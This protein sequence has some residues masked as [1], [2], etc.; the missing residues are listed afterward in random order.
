[1]PIAE[2]I[3]L[4]HFVK[5]AKSTA[6][7]H[8]EERKDVVLEEGEKGRKDVFSLLV[9]ANK[10]E[11]AKYKMSEDKI[12]CQFSYVL[13]FAIHFVSQ[14]SVIL[15]G[16]RTMVLAGHDTTANTMSWTLYERS[17]RPE[18]QHRLRA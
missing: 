6:K 5:L 8:I 15:H 9:R 10:D 7:K 13:N 16:D 12:Y 17:K 2:Y 14:S 1:M 3:K 18:V 11:E 4:R